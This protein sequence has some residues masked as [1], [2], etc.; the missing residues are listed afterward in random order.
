M[1]SIQLLEPTNVQDAVNR[2]D[3]RGQSMSEASDAGA[4]SSLTY[5]AERLR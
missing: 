3:K 4:N 2:F 5:V 1:H